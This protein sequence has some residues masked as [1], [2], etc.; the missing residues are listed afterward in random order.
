VP[1][2]TFSFACGVAFAY[3]ALMPAAL[4]FLLGFGDDSIKVVPTDTITIRCTYDNPGSTTL[5]WGEG[6]ADE[7]CLAQV[8]VVDQL[9]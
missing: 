8:Q 1:G 9:P 6:T 3:F 5:T 4:T 2:A 7:M